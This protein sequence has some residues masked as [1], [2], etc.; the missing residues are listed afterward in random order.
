MNASSRAPTVGALGDAGAV[1]DDYRDA[2]GRATQEQLPG[3]LGKWLI[4][5][6]LT[7]TL[8][9]RRGSALT[10]QPT[11]LCCLATLYSCDD[12]I[13]LANAEIML[14]FYNCCQTK[15]F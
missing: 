12:F 13:E 6:L 2:G 15:R 9:N 14:G 5:I 3:R 8:S 10:M 11:V 4:F 7:P 1:A